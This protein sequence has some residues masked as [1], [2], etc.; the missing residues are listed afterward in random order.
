MLAICYRLCV[1][2]SRQL[3]AGA[4]ICLWVWGYLVKDYLTCKQGTLQ[5]KLENTQLCVALSIR[6]KVCH[7]H[8]DNKVR[9]YFSIFAFLNFLALT[10][11]TAYKS[12]RPFQI[13]VIIDTLLDCS[14]EYVLGLLY[15]IGLRF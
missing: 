9:M 4:F 10:L 11:G 2:A 8:F 14:S 13:I 15:I 1:N 3:V 12:E 6:L 7:H 5:I